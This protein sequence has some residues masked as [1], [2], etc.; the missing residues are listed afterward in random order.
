MNAATMLPWR[1]AECCSNAT[2]RP[3]IAHRSVLARPTRSRQSESRRALRCCAG[4]RRATA[5][6]EGNGRRAGA[7]GGGVGARAGGDGAASVGMGGR[8]CGAATLASRGGGR[9]RDRRALRALATRACDALAMAMVVSARV[10]I[11]QSR[12]EPR[13]GDAGRYRCW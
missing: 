11:S 13:A 4:G 6:A 8:R 2:R 7:E 9:N 12:D 10:V 3:T 5:A 1:A